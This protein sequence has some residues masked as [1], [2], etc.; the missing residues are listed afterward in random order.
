MLERRD[1][2]QLL[3]LGP[4][5]RVPSREGRMDLR[6]AQGNLVY[7]VVI[8]AIRVRNDSPAIWDAVRS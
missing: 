3:M 8:G 5:S 6:T 2:L 1:N 7:P 4:V